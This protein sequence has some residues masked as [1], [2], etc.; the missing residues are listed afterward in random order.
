MNSKVVLLV[1]ILLIHCALS[2]GAIHHL[3]TS[4]D[5]RNWFLVENFGFSYGGLINITVKNFQATPSE[6]AVELLVVISST[7]S[8]GV[9][10]PCSIDTNS[11]FHVLL[12]EIS[13]HNKFPFVITRTIAPQSDPATIR[14]EGLYSIYYR[15]KQCDVS[16]AVSLDMDLVLANRGPDGSLDYLSA[17][18]AQLP[19][20]F[21]IFF[22][23]H[24]ALF[25]IWTIH[26]LRHRAETKRIHYLMA[27]LVMLKLLSLFFDALKYH[28]VQTSGY[29]IGMTV[30]YYIFTFLKGLMLFT[31]IMLIGAGYSLIKPF[32]SDR[33]KK[34]F[35]VVL[36]LQL[37][38]NVAKVIVDETIP[39]SQSWIT[40][41]DVFYLIDIVCCCAIMMPIVWSIRHLREASE[42]DGKAAFNMHKLTLFRQ[43]YIMI[44]TYIYF[45]RI[46]V[47][48][49]EATLP[50]RLTWLGQ[51]F[52]ELATF[53]FFVVTGYLFRPVPENPYLK[54]D[55][56][57]DDDEDI[58]SRGAMPSTEETGTTA[59]EMQTRAP[60]EAQ[61]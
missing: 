39:G 10:D 13:S 60:K 23:V 19:L 14:Q 28:F 54:V 51:L 26:I 18:D 20:I 52:Q 32:L 35:L 42:A 8:S 1:S 50:F 31:I 41:S 22:G 5:E 15:K 4:D 48:L 9:A 56:G 30:M 33:E 57:D 58:E 12:D 29:A 34:I 2:W 40:W 3:R 61:D 6:T 53:I 36:P 44:I 43:F 17:G 47:F 21:F 24:G 25:V 59:I 45:T 16:S 55:T 11:Q 38:A 46:V 7:D 27:V 37:L 49:M